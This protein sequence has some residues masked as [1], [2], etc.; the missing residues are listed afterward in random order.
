MTG[1]DLRRRLEA[2]FRR[3]ARQAPDRNQHGTLTD[4]A[5]AVRPPSFI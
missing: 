3:L 2:S 5:N 1:P 4:L